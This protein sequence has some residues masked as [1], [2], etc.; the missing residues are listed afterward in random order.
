MDRLW[1]WMLRFGG[2]A[3]I[4][5]ETIAFDFQRPIFLLIFAAMMGLADLT[6]LIRDFFSSLAGKIGGRGE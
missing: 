3:G 1:K 4:I 2:L 5:H 6:D